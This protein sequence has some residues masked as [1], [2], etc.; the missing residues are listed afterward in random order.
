MQRETEEA[1]ISMEE[2]VRMKVDKK[3]LYMSAQGSCIVLSGCCP[4]HKKSIQL[5]M[6][7]S[8]SRH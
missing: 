1:R 3:F 8:V 5:S 4:F 2:I 7:R 6:T